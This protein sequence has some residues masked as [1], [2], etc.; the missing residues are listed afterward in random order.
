MQ[1]VKL[2]HIITGL[3]QGGA[4]AILKKLVFEID[5][6]QKHE[7]IVISLTKLDFH[8]DEFKKN[9]IE[10]INLNI[11]NIFDFKQILKL[12]S[13]VKFINPSV[14]FTWMYHANFIGGLVCKILGINKIYWNIHHAYI[15]SNS[16]SISTRAIVYFSAI[17]SYIVPNKIIF[18]SQLGFVNHTNIFFSKRRSEIIF[19]GYESEFYLPDSSLRNTLRNSFSISENVIVIGI[20]ARW[21]PV[22]DHFNFIEAVN[23]LLTNSD[24]DIIAFMVGDG[25]TNNNF[26]IVNLLNKYQII[27]KF[28]L[29]GPTNDVVS[30][31]NLFDLN[32]LASKAEAFPNTLSESMLC[33]TPCVST[34]VG[35]AKLIVDKFGWIAKPSDSNDLFLQLNNA[36]NYITL[37]GKYKL[38]ND[39]R[40]HI[41]DKFSFTEM[42]KKFI[43]LL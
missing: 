12:Y 2:L 38:G 43:D 37:N 14:V 30:M 1:K 34:D 16:L 23:R 39:A 29:A 13:I 22:K 17:L 31:Y 40:S 42:K 26:E 25:I 8:S 24:L 9:G 35:D 33:C 15:D 21:H 18:C 20:V 19:N 32:V 4:E 36:V 7:Q 3:G 5:K 27:D 41:K 6:D 28:I 11:S 10:V